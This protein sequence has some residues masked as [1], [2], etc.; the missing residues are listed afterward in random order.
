MKRL[1]SLGGKNIHFELLKAR[2]QWGYDCTACAKHLLKAGANPEASSTSHKTPIDVADTLKF[3][4]F[5]KMLRDHALPASGDNEEAS[6]AAEG[7]NDV[8]EVVDL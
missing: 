3:I 1:G 7:E 2:A 4:K 6:A 8:D 5:A